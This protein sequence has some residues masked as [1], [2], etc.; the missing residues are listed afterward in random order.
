M[1]QRVLA[2]ILAAF[3]VLLCLP[4]GAAARAQIQPTSPHTLRQVELLGVSVFTR[5][6][7]LRFLALKPGEALQAD[8]AELA[9]DLETRY[10]DE[11]YTGARATATFDAAAGRLT[12]A[13]DEGRID[14]IEFEGVPASLAEKLAG[15]FAVQPGD[16]FNRRSVRRAIQRLLA[17]AGG[18]IE[19]STRVAAEAVVAGPGDL[20]R[21]REGFELVDRDGARVLRIRLRTREG[22]FALTVGT[23]GREDW[24]TPVDGFAPALGFRAFSFDP[25]SFNHTFVGGRLSYKFAREEAGF[26]LGVERP[27]LTGRRGFLG[28][29]VYDLTGTDDRWRL[30]PTEQS[31]AV[32]VLGK[33]FRD[34][35][36]RRGFQIHGSVM[37]L[38]GHELLVGW[39]RETHRDLINTAEFNL[40]GDADE[41]FRPNR[42]IHEGRLRS[43]ILRYTWDPRHVDGERLDRVHER[44]LADDL[45]GSFGGWRP[46]WRVEWT[47]EV[48]SKSFAGDFEF[49]RHILNA[50]SYSAIS[51]HQRFHARLV[52]GLSSG[53]LPPQR[54]FALGGVGT[55]RGYGFKEVAGPGMVLMNFE[56]RVQPRHV[57]L[58]AFFDAGRVFDGGVTPGGGDLAERWLNG[59]GIGLLMGDHA[60]VELAWRA[61]D[62]P[63]RARLLIRFAP[64]F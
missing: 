18:A 29:S 54:A 44:H 5:E 9:K 43:F 60:R 14:A 4:G 2:T 62:F 21:R 13:I 19:L 45:F 31:L 37:P 8:P 28:A 42:A 3:I 33:T 10:H 41:T 49:R 51:P 52:V 39:R 24:Y 63:K 55:V 46:G 1:P 15:S 47:S 56:Y 38:P 30:G 6:E 12:L 34:Y 57:G 25:E 11:G 20:D 27:F 23:G 7:V 59:P 50:R 64:A 16:I 36:Q 53:S 35:Y 48:A 32:L 58:L 22:A 40:F 17:P 26:A 61:D